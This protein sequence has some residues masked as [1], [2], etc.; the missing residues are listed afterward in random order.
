MSFFL[1]YCLFL[2]RPAWLEG[3]KAFKDKASALNPDTGVDEDLA[4]MIKDRI[5][6]DQKLAVGKLEYKTIIESCLVSN[7]LP[8]LLM[9]VKNSED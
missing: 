1:T 7:V 3:F 6:P 5:K 2:Q 8:C 4:F 9:R